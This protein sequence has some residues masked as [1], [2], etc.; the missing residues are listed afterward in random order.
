MSKCLQMI[1]NV[2]RIFIGAMGPPGA[3]RLAS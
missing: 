1:A 2:L 3:G